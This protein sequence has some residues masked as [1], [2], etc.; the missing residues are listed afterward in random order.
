MQHHVIFSS[1]NMDEVRGLAKFLHH[2]DIKKALQSMKGSVAF[3]YH[4][5][6]E[7]LQLKYIMTKEDFD[8]LVR[9]T[10]WITD[11]KSIIHVE[12]E[13]KG[14]M[15]ASVEQLKTSELSKLGR[16]T[17]TTKSK[18][19]LFEQWFYR[20]DMNTYWIVE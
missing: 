10:A 18:A 6:E 11:Q 4:N 12:T 2:L 3:C 20:S 5:S 17:Q 16:V 13:H 7:T 19:A 9:N 1:D 8:K 15:V 14:F